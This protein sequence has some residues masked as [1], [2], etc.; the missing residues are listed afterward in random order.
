MLTSKI[1]PIVLFTVAVCCHSAE[2]QGPDV[3]GRPFRGFFGGGPP[4]D[5]N[6][7]RQE[8]T[9][10]ANVLAGYDDNLS[11]GSGSADQGSRQQPGSRGLGSAALRFWSGRE[12]RS[13]TTTG[14]GYATRYSSTRRTG[15]GGDFQLEGMTAVGRA[16]RLSAEARASYTPFFTTGTFGSLSNDMDR[17]LSPDANPLNGI[18]G[19]HSWHSGGAVTFGRRWT[20]HDNTNVGYTY[21]KSDYLGPSGFDSEQHGLTVDYSR[22]F[23]SLNIKPSYQRSEQHLLEI[24]QADHLIT[25]ESVELG[26]IYQTRPS[27]NRR[28]SLTGGVG[29]TRTKEF[30][31]IADGTAGE[32]TPAG[33]GSVGLGV[34]RTWTVEL[35]YRRTMSTLDAIS[36]RPL[37]TDAAFVRLGG[38]VSRKLELMLSGGYS[39]GRQTSIES[40]GQF[41]SRSGSAEARYRLGRSVGVHVNYTYFDSGM[42][43]FQELHPGIPA[44]ITRNVVNVG[45]SLWLP[46]YGTWGSTQRRPAPGRS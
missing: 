39:A 37:A 10:T 9:A 45:F 2:A 40:A 25:L 15:I 13:L 29:A 17:E 30:S 22:A 42:R 21:S 38:S 8:L 44:Q 33:H 7:S 43:G 24:G 32:W 4:P 20:R 14:R 19:Q 6:R 16:S 28:L 5:P 18:E 36:R 35:D 41:T 3:P 34:G 11:E 46:L 31:P 27:R 26:A 1:L 12:A 23:G